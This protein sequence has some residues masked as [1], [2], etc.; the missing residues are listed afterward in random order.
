MGG[1]AGADGVL[2]VVVGV[3]SGAGY[4]AG[5]EGVAT[6]DFSSGMYVGA[7]TGVGVGLDIVAATLSFISS[8][9]SHPIVLMISSS[10][11][12][13]I[14]T[15]V[16]FFIQAA[17]RLFALSQFVCRLTYLSASMLRLL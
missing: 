8:T 12:D 13:I 15:V 1:S 17:S 4:V 3:T 10:I 7:D 5:A 11:S 9:L 14:N 16:T 6:E 2:V